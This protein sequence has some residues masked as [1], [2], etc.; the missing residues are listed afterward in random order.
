MMQS[1]GCFQM[2]ILGITGP[3]GAGKTTVSKLFEKSGIKV[4]DTDIVAREIVEPGKPALTEL[5]EYFGDEILLEN[6]E[7]NRRELARRAFSN[8]DSHMMLN[9][10]THHYITIEVD[11][12]IKN[13]DGDII[14]IDGAVLIES[15]IAEKCDKVLSVLA[16]KEI[17][18]DRITKRDSISVEDAELRISSQKNNEFYIENSDYLVYNNG[19]EDL[20]KEILKIV[21]ELR[22]MV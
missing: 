16:D 10:I 19:S 15:G 20:E 5:C 21:N 8:P 4:I 6:G 2:I 1:K 3:T 22:S 9:K 18:I 11:N 7:L 12:T 13:Y 17:R 14:G